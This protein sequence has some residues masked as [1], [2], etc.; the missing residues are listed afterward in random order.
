MKLDQLDQEIEN[1]LSATSSTDSTPTLHQ[2]HYLEATPAAS[3]TLQPL[4]VTATFSSGSAKSH[5]AKPKSG[6]SSIPSEKKKAVNLH[7]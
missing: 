2:R 3:L 5:K 6:S 7:Q 1:A 4:H